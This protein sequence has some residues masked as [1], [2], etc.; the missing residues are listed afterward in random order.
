MGSVCWADRCLNAYRS[1][2]PATLIFATRIGVEPLMTTPR[3]SLLHRIQRRPI[4]QLVNSERHYGCMASMLHWVLAALIIALVALGIYMVRLPDIGFDTK[5]IILI[6]IHKELGV[7]AL[8]LAALRLV[9]RQLNPLPRLAETVPEWQQVAAVFVHLCFY[10]LMLAQPVTGWLMSSAP[11][12]PVEFLGLFT[13]PDLV[14]H[15]DDL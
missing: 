8:A 9:W 6:L 7:L 15:D 11:G 5:K 4:M 12:I 3:D 1:G 14:R 2:G 10:A 13:L